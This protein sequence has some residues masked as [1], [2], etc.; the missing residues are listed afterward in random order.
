MM[1]SNSSA[2]ADVAPS[3]ANSTASVAHIDR[4]KLF[5]ILI[6]LVEKRSFHSKVYDPT[7]P[8]AQYGLD[9]VLIACRYDLQSPQD[10]Y[11]RCNCALRS[12]IR[13]PEMVCDLM[14]A[15]A[16]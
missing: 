2:I 14:R 6:P 7:S 8:L 9:L 12:E 16:R 1:P 10:V 11:L 5:R 3:R 15:N 13:A 4:T